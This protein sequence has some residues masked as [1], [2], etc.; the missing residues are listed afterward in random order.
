PQ[1]EVTL[2]PVSVDGTIAGFNLVTETVVNYT[3]DA[4]DIYLVYDIVDDIYFITT[5]NINIDIQDMGFS[6]DFDQINY[7]PDSGWSQFIDMELILGHTYV[8]W[9]DTDNY[10]KLRPINIFNSGA[11]RFEWAYQTDSGNR[12]LKVIPPEGQ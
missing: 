2:Y 6:Y 12:E 5:G 10:A 3:S 7:A 4:A 11:V 9:T 8:I 1:G